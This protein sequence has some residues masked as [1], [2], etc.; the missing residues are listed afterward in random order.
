M[1]DQQSHLSDGELCDSLG[2]SFRYGMLGE[3]AGE[4]K[5]DGGLDLMRGD[6]GLIIVPTKVGGLSGKFLKHVIYE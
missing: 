2:A 4:D 6:G 3:L 5:A 1:R